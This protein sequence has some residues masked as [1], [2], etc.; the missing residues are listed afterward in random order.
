MR[1]LVLR[2][3]LLTGIRVPDAP[4]PDPRPPA[5]MGV[6]AARPRLFAAHETSGEPAG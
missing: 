5:A 4:G 2:H 1:L 3:E 6:G